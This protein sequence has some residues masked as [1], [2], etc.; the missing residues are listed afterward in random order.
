MQGEIFVYLLTAFASIFI[1]SR[2]AE[3]E[4]LNNALK[5]GVGG[6]TLQ[7]GSSYYLIGYTN[8]VSF[9]D[10]SL[11]GDI[12]IPGYLFVMSLAFLVSVYAFNLYKYKVAIV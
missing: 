9:I 7:I 11:N 10:A 6:S 3:G 2:I 4:F 12:G 8:F 5:R 1:V